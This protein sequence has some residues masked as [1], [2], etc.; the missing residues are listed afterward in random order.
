MEVFDDQQVSTRHNSV[1]DEP[2]VDGDKY[3]LEMRPSERSEPEIPI[4]SKEGGQRRSHFAQNS[5]PLKTFNR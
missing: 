5:P 2:T 4:K 1:T 3:I